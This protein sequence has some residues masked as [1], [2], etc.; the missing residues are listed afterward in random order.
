MKT[1]TLVKQP[2]LQI[3]RA[4]GQRCPEARPDDSRCPETRRDV[5]RCLR[6]SSD[7]Q[8]C[9]IACYPQANSRPVFD[10]LI[11]A[12]QRSGE[13]QHGSCIATCRC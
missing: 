8:C 5:E 11:T 13:T 12:V 3:A 4:D 10:M 6:A 9:A 2:C 1:T 7:D